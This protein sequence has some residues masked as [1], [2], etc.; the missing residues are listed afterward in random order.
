[1][2]FDI[3]KASGGVRTLAAPRPALKAIQRTILREMLRVLPTH[4]AAHGF[5]PG[6]SIMTNAAPHVGAALVV[7]LDLRDFF[8]SVHYRRVVGLFEQLGY[9][10]DVAALLAGLTTHCRLLPDGRPAW[11][12]VLP[13]GA[14]TSPVIANLVC[15]R[16]DAR[17]TGLSTS[18]GAVYTRY[19][20]DLT[21]SF[22]APPSRGIGR[23][24]WWVEAICQQEGFSENVSKRRI[25]RPSN[26]QRITG[27]VVNDG[28]SV[29]LE[30][31]R[32]FRA[33][34]AN[35]ERDGLASQA[36]GRPDFGDYLVGFASYL[37]MVHPE[38]GKDLLRRARALAQ[39]S[40][41]P[42]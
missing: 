27:I 14:P 7:K 9:R 32:R 18:V 5:V 11:P 6:R 37:A 17:L 26:Q 38:Q 12:G 21:F 25:L 41:A 19:A 24:F 31:R 34:L 35:C 4:E 39:K 29:P 36:R 23:F 10:E 8:P 2:E 33:T 28:L 1:V 3:P 42:V 22:P 16:L 15:R 13:Q 30:E 40:S 20:D